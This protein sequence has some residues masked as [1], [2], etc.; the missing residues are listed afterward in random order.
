MVIPSDHQVDIR[1][2]CCWRSVQNVESRFSVGPKHAGKFG[3]VVFH[4]KRVQYRVKRRPE[5]LLTLLPLRRCAIG[6]DQMSYD[7][8]DKNNSIRFFA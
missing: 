1:P 2:L 7:E 3:N 6:L 5:R 4:K 8:T